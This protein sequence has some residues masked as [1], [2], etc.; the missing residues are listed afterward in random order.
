MKKI[1]GP[2]SQDMQ[3]WIENL[4]RI[5]R[6]D[7][8]LERFHRFTEVIWECDPMS[9][10]TQALLVTKGLLWDA[11]MFDR[12]FRLNTQEVLRKA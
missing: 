5:G 8:S 7:D 4:S 1:S 12:P 10:A 3:E 11:E 2:S 6:S 9:P